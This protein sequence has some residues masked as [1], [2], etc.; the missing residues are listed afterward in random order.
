MCLCRSL[1]V[2]I[3]GTNEAPITPLVTLV[4]KERLEFFWSFLGIIIF[5]FLFKQQIFLSENVQS[6]FAESNF[7]KS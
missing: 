1:A 6:S 5:L 2:I 3:V 7:Q 4:M